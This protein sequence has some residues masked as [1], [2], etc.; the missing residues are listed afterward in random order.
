MCQ[1]F[2]HF[3]RYLHYYHFVF[4]KSTNVSEEYQCARISVIF[5]DFCI[6]SAKLASNNIRVK[7]NPCL[8]WISMYKGNNG[9]IRRLNM[10]TLP[11]PKHCHCQTPTQIFRTGTPSKISRKVWLSL[12]RAI[13][14]SNVTSIG[15]ISTNLLACPL[16]RRGFKNSL[17]DDGYELDL[18]EKLF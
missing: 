11:C 17:N 4:Q 1:G 12:I 6:I 2:S 16:L 10:C 3:A 9:S 5:Q 13:N 18:L 15:E 7:V 14:F 8:I